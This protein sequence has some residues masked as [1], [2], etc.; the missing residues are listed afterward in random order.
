MLGWLGSDYARTPLNI[1]VGPKIAKKL[2]TAFGMETVADA[3]TNFPKRYVAQGKSLDVSFS[4]IGD[5]I[6]TVVEVYN[7][8]PAP[9]VP[10]RR[11]PLKIIVSDGVR[12]LPAAIFG[13]EWLRNVLYQGVRLLIVGT[14][15]EFRGELQLKNVDCMVLKPDGSVGAATGKLA[16]LTKSA[17]GVAE[18]QR[19]LTRPYLPIYRGR[20]GVAGIH[21]A[22]YMQRVLEWLPLQPEPL[23][24]TPEGLIDFDQALRGAHFPSVAGPDIAIARLKYDE[25]LEL[26]LAVGARKLT[27]ASLTAPVCTEVAAGAREK[28]RQ[29]LPF[30]LTDGQSSVAADIARDMAADIPMNRLL[31]GEVGSGKTVVAL[32][33]MLQAVDAGRQCAMLAPTE[34]LSQQ[35]YRSLSAMLEKAGVD[36][37]VRLLTGSMGTK[38]RRQTLLEAIN[39]Q[40]D[41]VVG[42]HALLSDGVEFF[43][44]GLVV[45]D[46]Q[47]RFGVRQRDQLRSRGRNGLTPHLLVMSATPIPRTVAM[48][49]FGDLAV[50]QLTE[51]PHGR[52]E[53]QSFVVPTL[54]KPRWE[55]RTWERIAEEVAKGNRAFIVCPRIERDSEQFLDESVEAVYERAQ[56]KLPNLRIGQLHGN[57]SPET[58]DS[59]MQAFAAGQLDVLVSTTVIEVGVDVPE[60]TVMMIR[61]AESFGIS[62]IH[63]LRGRVGRGDRGGLCFLCTHTHDQTPER[64]RLER[65]AATNDGI[66]LAELDLATRSF[67]DLLGD[68]QSGL[69]T[70]L[71]L[72]DLTTDGEIIE[73]TRDDAAVLLEDNRDLVTALISDIDEEQSNYLDR[74]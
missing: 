39:G 2:K 38:E 11:K 40:A 53:I 15:S 10:D 49:I 58:K 35:H 32:L 30:S 63:Q 64:T 68:D 42:T 6:T 44:L 25:A 17:K 57:L 27:Q 4:D 8:A 46:E 72:V 5:T 71:G 54:E 41:I 14:L 70:G 26:Q 60:A 43:D 73:R 34:V 65:I 61:K 62:Q 52:Q 24:T 21:L 16:T 1:V 37:N 51:L 50:S 36:V 33:G 18:M 19:L 28:L 67:G 3:L 66:Q 20:K 23:P 56:K 13:A 29:G 48:T 22:L 12:L 55:A 9:A 74:S 47:H 69:A 45:V 7:V 59:V 31:A